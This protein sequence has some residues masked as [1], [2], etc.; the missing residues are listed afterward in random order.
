MSEQSDASTEASG[1]LAR[2]LMTRREALQRVAGLL[3]GTLVG[4]TALLS[5]CRRTPS[6]AAQAV[7]GLFSAGDLALLDDITDTILPE[8]GTPGAKSAQ[9]VAVFGGDACG[10]RVRVGHG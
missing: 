7:N 10:K 3:G 5:G 9:P 6:E 2:N 1:A 4:G 8:T